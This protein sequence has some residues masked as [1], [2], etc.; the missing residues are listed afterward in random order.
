MRIAL[1]SALPDSS[2][3]SELRP[4]FRRFAGKS[5]ICHQIDC[6]A[7]LECDRVLC[8]TT[9][10]GQE[11]A[12]AQ[13]YARTIGLRFETLDAPLALAGKVS[14]SDEVIVLADGILPDRTALRDHLISGSAILAFPADKAVPLGY[15]RI[16]AARAWGGALRTAGSAVGRLLDLPPDC[17]VPSSLLRIS[18]Q[19]GTP[20]VDCD[21]ELLDQ[22]R[23]M[24]RVDPLVTA[25]GEWDWVTRQIA[26]TPFIAPVAALTERIGLRLSHSVQNARWNALPTSVTVAGLGCAFIALVIGWPLLALVFL[27]LAS[28]SLDVARVFNRVLALGSLPRLR[29]PTPR[30]AGLVRDGLFVWGFG[31]ISRTE[32]G[33]L[34]FFL[35]AALI[36][37]LHIGEQRAPTAWSAAYTDRSLVLIFI[38]VATLF[39]LHVLVAAGLL[40]V[41][42]TGLL[43][44]PQ[45]SRQEITAD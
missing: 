44:R 7:L 8:L 25:T 10:V 4:S 28:A 31:L 33:W 45:V 35:A 5:V 36:A 13:D 43:I 38:I 34:G 17:D 41:A 21:A 11:L 24:R 2:A 39:E 30:I 37:V 9:G 6:A 14:A 3:P 29:S 22:N 32:P 26:L 16:D 18:L 42:L 23:W 12:A 40:G 19:S 27:L 1:L 15:E 20:V